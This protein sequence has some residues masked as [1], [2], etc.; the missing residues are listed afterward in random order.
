MWRLVHDLQPVEARLAK[1]LPNNSPSCKY[2]CPDP[3]ADRAH[4]Y[5]A[6]RLTSEVGQWLL[7]LIHRFDPTTTP[8]KLLRLEFEAGE[9]SE[10]LVWI[11]VNTLMYSWM[12]RVAGKPARLTDCLASLTAEAQLLSDTRHRGTAL[13][14]LNLLN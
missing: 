2:D 9:S 8:V 6:C 12:R 5:L 3:T 1:I 13:V 7:S 14:V 10:G 4:C 11:A